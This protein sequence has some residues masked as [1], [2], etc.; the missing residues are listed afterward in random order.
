MKLRVI[1]I[2][3]LAVV[4]FGLS[5]PG[6]ASA[7]CQIQTCDMA[8]GWYYIDGNW[9]YD[10]VLTCVEQ[11][12]VPPTPPGGN[13]DPP[14]PPTPTVCAPDATISSG[15]VMSD[16]N[17]YWSTTSPLPCTGIWGN[18]FEFSGQVEN[19]LPASASMQVRYTHDPGIFTTT[20]LT[21]GPILDSG[22]LSTARYGVGQ[23]PGPFRYEVKAT[24]TCPNLAPRILRDAGS[25]EFKTPEL[26]EGRGATMYRG[27]VDRVIAGD[28]NYCFPHEF[29]F[30]ESFEAKSTASGSFSVGYLTYELGVER[31]SKI[32]TGH[33]IVLPRDTMAKIYVVTLQEDIEWQKFWYDWLGNRGEVQEFGILHHKILSPTVVPYYTCP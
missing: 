24:L 6:D 18:T 15:F 30:T 2:L 8:C 21:E 11:C 31:T 1:G 7:A 32:S 27:E 29:T 23:T 25:C 19:Y 5:L 33:K 12:P 22:T 3:V 10:C 20:F 28:K 14:S 13:P 9:L 26:T 4:A 16:R 17:G